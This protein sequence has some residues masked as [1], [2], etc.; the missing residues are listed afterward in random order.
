MA[1]PM[2]ARRKPS[3]TEW[4][5]VMTGATVIV[6]GLLFWLYAPNSALEWVENKANLFY[7]GAKHGREH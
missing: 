4:V 6:F 1:T 5:L 7:Q 3:T 2:P